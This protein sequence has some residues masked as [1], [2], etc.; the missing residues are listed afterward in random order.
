M[1]KNDIDLPQYR[2]LLLFLRSSNLH[3]I[4]LTLE[5]YCCNKK[6]NIPIHTVHALFSLNS[7]LTDQFI[8]DV[9]RVIQLIF[10]NRYNFVNS[11]P[12]FVLKAFFKRFQMII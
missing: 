3:N 11:T 5:S 8:Q 6:K 7:R 10:L 9:G 12:K 4:Y 1:S 2:V